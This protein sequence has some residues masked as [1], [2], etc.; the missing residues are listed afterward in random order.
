[1]AFIK[2]IHPGEA[3]GKLEKIYGLVSGPGGQ[4]DNVLQVHSLRPHTLEGHMCLYKSVL[5]DTRNRLPHWYSESIGVLVSRLNE[6][7]YCDRHH[8]A[9]LKRLLSGEKRDFAAYDR[10]LS[11]PRPGAPFTAKEQ[12]GLDYARKLTHAPGAIEQGDIDFLRQAGFADGEILELNQV[13]SYFAYANRTVTGLGVSV[14]GEKL[15]LSP[16]DADDREAWHHD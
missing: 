1:M 11:R 4:V 12:A 13:A 8:S 10:A 2:V 16:A 7:D 9:G 5:H 14:G 3:T 15:G 6:C